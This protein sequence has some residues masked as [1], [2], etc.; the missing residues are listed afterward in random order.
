MV[1]VDTSIWIDHL[2]R[3]FPALVDLL[4]HQRVLT[5]PFVIGELACGN[6]KNRDEI[7]N[8]LTQLPVIKS[9]Q[10][11][12][13][14]TMISQ[15]KLHGRGLGWVDVHLL[16]ACRISHVKLITRDRRLRE[17]AQQLNCDWYP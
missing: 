15:Q 3:S 2:R 9:A 8:H 1:L 16:A 6:L 12:E 13:V 11:H 7:L 17:A 10:Y 4:E 14:M 5:H